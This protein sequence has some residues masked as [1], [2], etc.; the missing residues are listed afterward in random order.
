MLMDYIVVVEDHGIQSSPGN[1]NKVYRSITVKY[2][3]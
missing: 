2:G 3:H 1:K